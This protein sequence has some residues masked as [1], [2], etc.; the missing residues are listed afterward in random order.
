MP[1]TEAETFKFGFSFWK[2]AI[3]GAMMGAVNACSDIVSVPV[4]PELD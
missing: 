2:A 3:T 1:C 4:R